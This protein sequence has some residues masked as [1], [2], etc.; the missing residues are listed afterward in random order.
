MKYCIIIFLFFLSCKKQENWL[1][2]KSNKADIVP[3]S[4]ADFQAVLDNDAVMNSNY[5]ALGLMGTDNYYLFFTTWQALQIIERNTYVWKADLY[6]GAPCPDWNNPYI[7]IEYANICL[8]GILKITPDVNTQESWNRVKG[9]ALFYRAYA[10]YNLAQLFAK[11][12]NRTTASADPGI[13]LRLHSDVNEPSVRASI[14]Q[15]YSRIIDD[16]L[17]A[18]SLLPVTP[19]VKTRPSQ[20]SVLAL[21]ARVSLTMENYSRAEQYASETL[22]LQS[23]LLDFNILNAASS[24]PMPTFQAD[25]K[26]VIFYSNSISFLTLFFS[27]MKVDTVLYSSYTSNDLRKNIFYKDN[28]INGIAFRGDYNGQ[29]AASKFS[30]LAVNELYLIRSESFARQNKITEA[31]TDLNTVREKRFKTGTFIP[32]T[33]V[34][35]N[36]ALSKI[37]TERRKELPFT[38]ELPWEDLRRLNKDP[39]FA[40]YLTR[41]LNGQVYSLLPGDPRYVYP[42]PDNEIRYSGIVQNP[43]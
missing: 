38:G 40:R 31:M 23:D 22:K 21:L 2:K 13:I 27:V 36:D 12:Y 14:E 35:S 41:K 17:E 28:G 26:E 33:A 20:K 30:G 19:A 7:M 18:K 5:P 24:N 6:E 4:I 43:R 15:T 1:D 34:N 32:L 10:F 37:L 29:V 16:L 11:P 9:S 39:A 3:V 42:I 25:N 8:D